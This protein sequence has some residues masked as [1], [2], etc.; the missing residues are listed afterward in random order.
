MGIGGTYHFLRD[1]TEFNQN[2]NSEDIDIT[3]QM[4]NSFPSATVSIQLGDQGVYLGCVYDYGLD[5]MRMDSNKWGAS[6]FRIYL[7]M[8][9][10]EMIKQRAFN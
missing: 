6:S 2:A 8:N 5:N 1:A 7:Q 4:K 10:S 3:D 9:I